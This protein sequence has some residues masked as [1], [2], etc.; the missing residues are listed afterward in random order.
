MRSRLSL[1]GIVFFLTMSVTAQADIVYLRDG[2]AVEGTF[3]GGNSRTVRILDDDGSMQTFSISD[4]ESIVFSSSSETTSGT[5]TPSTPAPV[6]LYTVPPGVF[7]VVRMLDPVDSDVHQP[8]D[9]FRA[10]LEEPIKVDGNVL[11]SEGSLV[12]VQLVHVKQSGQLKGEEEIALQLQS[13]TV[14]GMTHAL[15]TDFAEVA[16]EGKGGESAKV[17][18]GG[19]VIG[20]LIG[21]LA[22]GKKGAAIGAATG[23]GAGVAIQATR[24]KQ[25]RIPSEALLSFKLEESVTLR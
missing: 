2:S 22:G 12:A 1:L 21:A 18:G 16:S 15:T 24:G 14:N 23:A 25:V 11:A 20:A 9:S 13:I 5:L 19:A 10:T 17:V 8:G 4:V 3:L 7:L 6:D